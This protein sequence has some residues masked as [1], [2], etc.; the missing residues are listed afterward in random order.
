MIEA[1]D[2]IKQGTGTLPAARKIGFGRILSGAEDSQWIK[3]E[4]TIETAE[5][6]QRNIRLRLNT[7]AGGF[8]A[9]LMG[10]A[11]Q[12]N[13]KNWIGSNVKLTGV[14]GTWAN[15]DRQTIGIQFYIPN[16]NHIEFQRVAPDDPFDVQLVPIA[17]LLQFSANAPPGKQ[18]SKIAGRIIYVGDSGMV[19]IQDQSKAVMIEFPDGESPAHGT[20]V[21]V[22]GFPKPGPVSPTLTNAK[23]R[24]AEDHFI[25][26]PIEISI[27]SGREKILPKPFEGKMLISLASELLRES[28]YT[29]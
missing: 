26:Q 14:C 5:R 18:R 2:I 25:P 8:D 22:I 9:V 24:H 28:N 11:N 16:L 3:V 19:S 15:N 7:P 13:E 10:E 6:D 12:F 29:V 21:E 20:F 4:G 1:H 17:E 27:L 23:W